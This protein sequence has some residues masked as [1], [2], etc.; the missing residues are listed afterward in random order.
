MTD[1]YDKEEQP[2]S[3]QATETKKKGKAELLV[4]ILLAAAIVAAVAGVAVYIVNNRKSEPGKQKEDAAVPRPAVLVVNITSPTAILRNMNVSDN[5]SNDDFLGFGTA[6]AI[7]GDTAIAC[8]PFEHNSLKEQTGSCS[9][10]G[11]HDDESWRLETKVL[12]QPDWDLGFY[13][14]IAG[15]QALISG[16]DVV[17]SLSKEES[18]GAWQ[19]NQVVADKTESTGLRWMRIPLAMTPDRAFAMDYTESD[20][21]QYYALTSSGLWQNTSSTVLFPDVEA[22]VQRPHV[23]VTAMKGRTTAICAR[24]FANSSIIVHRVAD[25]DTIEH[26]ATIS[27][28]PSDSSDVNLCDGGVAFVDEKTIVTSAQSGVRIYK[29]NNASEWIEKQHISLQYDGIERSLAYLDDA[30]AATEDIIVVGIQLYFSDDPQYN[31]RD[32][33][34]AVVFK[35]DR[36]GVWVRASYLVCPEEGKNL[37]SWIRAATAVDVSGRSVILGIDRGIGVCIFEV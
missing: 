12:G 4:G 30:I 21:A 27:D 31:S 35:K 13:V 24:N 7:D 15:D 19:E 34:S 25:D 3:E 8:A 26:I 11:R 32:G 20:V 22:E 18:D 1:D 2:I 28:P 6:V 36:D 9:I 33:F 16:L 37:H 29:E 14:E 5:F 17:I 10:Y 23:S